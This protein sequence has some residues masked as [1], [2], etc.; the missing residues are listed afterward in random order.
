M[1]A[2]ENAYLVD[3]PWLAA[4]LDDVLVVDCR[5]TGD[6]DSSRATYRDGHIPHAVHSYWLDLCAEDTRVTTLLPDR[7]RAIAALSALGVGP[8]TLVVAYA[9]NADL[10]AARLWH[11]LRVLGHADVR[12]LDGGLAAWTADGRP[13][14]TGDVPAR[15]TR[16]QPG[17]PLDAAIDVDELRDRLAGLQIVDT[18][19]PEEFAGTQVRAAR[20]GHIPGALPL[21]WNDLIDD[22]GRYLDPAELRHRAGRAGLDPAAET[23]TYCQGGVRAAHAALGLRLAGFERVR[24]YDGSWAQWGNDPSLPVHVAISG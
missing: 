7:D 15:P 13:L 18:R 11:L 22:D 10:Y 1:T 20:G 23:V 19:S 2:T 4:H 21:P 17:A 9:D 3:A 14:A 16:F 8:T 12:L 24:V 5:F 6:R